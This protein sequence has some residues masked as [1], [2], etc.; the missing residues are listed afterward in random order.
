MSQLNVRHTDFTYTCFLQK[1]PRL[2]F[3]K[4]AMHEKSFYFYDGRLVELLR[5]GD[6][7]AQQFFRLLSLCHTV[8][9]E[10]KDGEK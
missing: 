1:T 2:D 4:N 5:S 8:M 9:P 7:N 10:E 3:S 6:A